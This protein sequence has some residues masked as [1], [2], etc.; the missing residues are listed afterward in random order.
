MDTANLRII[1][2]LK[3]FL[4]EISIHTDLWLNSVVSET[5]FTRNRCLPFSTLVL[6]ILNFPKRSLSLELKSFFGHIGQKSCSK[7]AFCIQ[8]SKLKP[9]FF[10]LWN[11]VLVDCFY[12]YYGDRVKRWKGFILLAFDG[13]IISLPGTDELSTVY[14]QTSNKSGKYGAAAHG[15]LMYDVLNELIIDG[16][17]M[18]C[19]T[20]EHAAVIEQLNHAPDRSLLLFD[21]GYACFWMFYLLLQEQ[22]HK[23]IVRMPSGLYN[24]VKSFECSSEQDSIVAFYPSFRAITQMK[25]MGIAI[26]KET[27][28]DLR[29]VKIPLKTGETEILATNLYSS[30]LYSA[31][32]LG[33]IYA[34]RWGIET[35]FDTL[36]NQLQIEV[37]SGIRQL[38]VEQDFLAN[39]FVYNLQSIIQKPCELVV[40]EISKHRKLNYKINKNMSWAF[41]KN[42]IVD[43]FFKETSE[44]IL[45]ELQALFEQHLEPVRP[46]RSYLRIIKTA[47]KNGKYNTATNYKRAI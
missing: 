35:C 5:A 4:M 23:F 8:R 16:K 24:A 30:K 22:E 2:D 18:P 14:G 17:L 33:K 46:N 20:R 9:F 11:Q 28:I 40:S 37:F 29:L 42:R 45:L 43:L 39:L 3:K 47:N 7:A 1:S 26:T 12:R 10:K 44:Q 6:M 19:L 36:K 27:R 32:E 13:S 41:L 21:R 38:C 31:N 25:K 34:L 15:C